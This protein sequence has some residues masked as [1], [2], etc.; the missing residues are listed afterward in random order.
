MH[1]QVRSKWPIFA[2]AIISLSVG[3]LYYVLFRPSSH[4]YVETT[5]SKIV[6][7][8]ALGSVIPDYL[9]GASFS[10]SL[11]LIGLRIRDSCVIVTSMGI[12][13]EV[14]QLLSGIGTPCLFDIV[15]Y[16]VGVS[17]AS[18]TALFVALWGLR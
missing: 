7:P 9:W 8:T 10:A 13:F 2:L 16:L 15:A 1:F 4:Y 17:T 14:W 18:V 11:I 5:F 12:I 3:F 6:I